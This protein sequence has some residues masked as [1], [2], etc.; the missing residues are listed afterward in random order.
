M[1]SM[2]VVHETLGLSKVI[3]SCFIKFLRVR[4]TL[5]GE[6]KGNCTSE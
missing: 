3:A 1:D 5:E 2:A 4:I 6:T